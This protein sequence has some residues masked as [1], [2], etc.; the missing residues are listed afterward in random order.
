[1]WESGPIR[2]RFDA[3]KKINISPQVVSAQTPTSQVGS[4][5]GTPWKN[6]V[7]LKVAVGIFGPLWGEMEV[8]GN[9]MLLTGTFVRSLDEKHRLAIPKRLRDAL[10][11]PLISLVFAPGTDG[12]FEKSCKVTENNYEDEARPLRKEFWAGS[13]TRRENPEELDFSEPF[14][15]QT[16]LL[17]V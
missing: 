16:D 10:G 13:L 17:G 6:R 3:A 11:Q 9:T 8:S 5:L 7:D 1:M 14:T 15:S 2:H 12:F 4:H